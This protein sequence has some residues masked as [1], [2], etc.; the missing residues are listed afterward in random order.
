[1]RPTSRNLFGFY[2]QKERNH[3]RQQ[4]EKRVIA[5]EQDQQL[6]QYRD[7][8]SGNPQAP[9]FYT[10]AVS[11]AYPAGM[12]IAPINKVVVPAR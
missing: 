2:D 12:S 10:L 3:D 4:I 11:Y 9:G 8:R 7:A 6:Q 5:R 1:M